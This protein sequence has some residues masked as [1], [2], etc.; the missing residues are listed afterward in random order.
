MSKIPLFRL[1]P[2]VGAVILTGAVPVRA[3]PDIVIADFE[4]AGYPPGWTTTGSAFGTGPAHGTLPNQQ[5]VSGYHG[6]VPVNSYR[7]G[8]QAVGTL[9]SPPFVIRRRYLSLRVGGGHHL[10]D[11]RIDLRVGKTVVRTATG[12]NS[13]R[14]MPMQWDVSTLQGKTAILRVTDT[15]TGQWGHISM[16]DLTLTDTKLPD[17]RSRLLGA[18]TA[19]ISAAIPVAEADPRRPGYHYHAPAQWMNDPNGTIFHDGWFHV[20]YQCNPYGTEWGH[21]H[22]GHARSKDLINWEQM[23]PALWP[24]RSAG[25]EHVFSGSLFPRADGTLMAFY[26][27]IGERDPQQWGALPDSSDLTRWHK[28]PGNPLLTNALHGAE[29]VAEWRDPFLFSDNRI[30]YML[31][32]GGL[33]GRGVVMLYQALNSDLTAWKSLGVVFQHPD[34]AL[35]NVE[36]PNLARIDGKWLLLT[37]TYGKVETFTGQLDLKARRFITEK[38]DI[39]MDGSYASQLLHAPDGTVTYLAWMRTE[40]GSGWNGYLTLPST[41]HLT[42]NGD[43][44]C[45]PAASLTKLRGQR[46]SVANRSVPGALDLT[47][48]MPGQISGKSLEIALDISPGTASVITLHL[49]ASADGARS[50]ALR[51]EVATRTLSV[52]GRAPAVLPASAGPDLTLHVFL[53]N[54]ALDV[55]AAGGL[56]TLA[57]FLPEIPSGD[58]G[59]QI[60]A[61][62]G[63]AVIKSLDL[64]EMKPAVFDA[65]RFAPKTRH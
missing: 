37:S 20:F 8:D 49:R 47:K 13:E 24:S 60:S 2:L 42:P 55:Y 27:S 64:Y 14:L 32:G 63:T 50:V 22:W 51:Y 41:L 52:P 9:T 39:L 21:M 40:K 44:V 28:I 53:D 33:S 38:R 31:V 57:S 11:T 12:D 48:Q 58:T 61:D 19:A 18:A 10:T 30:T 3:A 56:V 35:A 4:G 62:G 45:Q 6:S 34:A 25:E 29:P 15:A 1:W 36:C 59:V 23:P 54:G 16:D 5:A 17:E 43:V 65:T 7:D 26:T 46:G